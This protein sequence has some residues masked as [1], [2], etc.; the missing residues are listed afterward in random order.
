MRNTGV[1]SLKKSTG[2]LISSLIQLANE[3]GWDVN[4]LINDN[5][6]SIQNRELQYKSLGRKTRIA[7]YGGAFD[8]PHLGHI[9]VAQF[10]LNTSAYFDECWLLPAYSHRYNKK[11]VDAEHRLIM[12]EMAAKVDSRIKVF[13]YEIKNKLAGETYK[14]VKLL[15]DDSLFDD[16]EFSFIMGIDNANTFNKWVNYEHLE[17]MM[18]F[19]IVPRKGYDRDPSVDWYLQKPHI[20]LNKEDNEILEVSSTFIR[21]LIKNKEYTELSKYLN[22]EVIQYILENK[23]YV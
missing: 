5:L 9:Q 14:L 19:V 17:K 10:V 11:M 12:C 2:S 20:Y 13:D 7:I 18:K 6:N 8:M 23:L 4:D 22:E 16:F 3:S 1:K 21:T 15:K